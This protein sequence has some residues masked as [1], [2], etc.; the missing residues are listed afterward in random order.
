MNLDASDLQALGVSLR[1]AT[2]SVGCLLVLGAPLAWWLAR[3]KS[4]FKPLIEGLVALPLVLPPSV[5]G[6]YLLLL[7]GAR[8]P[9]AQV[10][11]SLAFTFS[12][13]VIGS[14]VFSLPFV[15]QPL[16]NS[17]AALDQRLLDVAA[18]M[19]AGKMDRFLTVVLPATRTGWIRAAMLG[20]AHTLGEF[21][22]VLMIGGNLAG[23]TRVAS[24]AIYNHVE[25]LNYPRA[26]EL[27]ATLVLL[28]LLL[29][30]MV[31]LLTRERRE[32]DEPQFR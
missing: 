26:H 29:M 16:Q 3:T 6:F 21:G 17:F 13:L 30:I 20:F 10:L 9:F 14:I 31:S 5:L 15:V 2:V 12:G 27:A 7:L 28:S 25:T 22:V 11:G 19:G 32:A 4:E 1:L 8:G 24:I 18:T 23:E